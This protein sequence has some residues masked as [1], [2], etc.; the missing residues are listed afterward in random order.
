[1]A[2]RVDSQQAKARLR[3][4]GVSKRFGATVALQDVGIEVASGEVL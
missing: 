1:M 4:Q 3:M 2:E